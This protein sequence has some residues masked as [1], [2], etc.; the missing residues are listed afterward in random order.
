MGE[1][2]AS[3]TSEPIAY[4]EFTAAKIFIHPSYN[5]NNLKND[6]ALIRLNAPVGLGTT[7]TI[8]TACMPATSFSSGRCWVS[9][10]GKNDFSTS[11]QFQ[12]IQKEVDVPMKSPTECQSALQSTRL[13]LGFVFDT[14]SFI[15]AGGEAGKDACTVSYAIFH[16]YIQICFLFSTN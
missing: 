13:G 7:P 5:A 3:A 16:H 11:G 15:C 6:I 4:Q 1:W 10:W 8:T 12:A 9:G 2:D 14:S